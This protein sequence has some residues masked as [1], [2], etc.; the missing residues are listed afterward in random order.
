MAGRVPAGPVEQQDRMRSPGHLARDRIEVKLH[1][2]SAGIGQSQTGTD[3][4]RRADRSEQIGTLIALVGRLARSGIAPGP[5]PHDP[6]LLT[7]ASFV[8]T[9]RAAKRNQISIGLA[10]GRWARCTFSVAGTFR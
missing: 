1:G 4:A 3:A 8:L 2:F 10:A 9:R 7:D 6:V 5:L